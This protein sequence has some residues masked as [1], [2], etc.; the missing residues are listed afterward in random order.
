MT[1]MEPT[2]SFRL[3]RPNC[4]KS[5]RAFLVPLP[6][7]LS[8]I[9]LRASSPIG[10][11]GVWGD[12]LC[13][14]KSPRNHQQ[15]KM[16]LMMPDLAVTKQSSVPLLAVRTNLT[17]MTTELIP[18][19][20]WGIRFLEKSKAQSLKTMLLVHLIR[21][22]KKAGATWKM[23]VI[24]PKNHRLTRPCCRQ[25]I[26][27]ATS[28]INQN[29]MLISHSCNRRQAPPLCQSLRHAAL[30]PFSPCHRSSHPSL[31][32]PPCDRDRLLGQLP[33]FAER[34]SVLVCCPFLS[35]FRVRDWCR[36]YP[37]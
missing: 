22:T 6:V 17:G 16:I 7:P 1:L 27:E 20:P 13:F 28:L 34:L 32:S 19:G 12:F 9:L 36:V 10:L 31:V 35:H 18:A 15:S 11:R 37:Y 3:P 4:R 23:R 29:R 26:R 21:S 33:I 30:D 25:A 5:S 8:H 24:E 2:R 14:R